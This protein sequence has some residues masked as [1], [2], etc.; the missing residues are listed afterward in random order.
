MFYSDHSN[1]KMSLKLPSTSDIDN[2]YNTA[3]N[4]QKSGIKFSDHIHD[5]YQ[6]IPTMDIDTS[7]YEFEKLDIDEIYDIIDKMVTDKDQRI[8]LQEQGL[9]I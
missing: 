6:N 3:I 2:L 7:I 1:G 5:L 8:I 4:M 9:L